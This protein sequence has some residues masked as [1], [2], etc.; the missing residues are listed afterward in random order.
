MLFF[1]FLSGHRFLNKAFATTRQNW[2]VANFSLF[3][4]D[5]VRYSENIT[6]YRLQSY[7]FVSFFSDVI[8]LSNLRLNNLRG[9]CF[10]FGKI[11]ISIVK[12]HQKTKTLFY[13]SEGNTFICVCRKIWTR[14]MLYNFLN[15]QHHSLWKWTDISKEKFDSERL[16]EVL[17]KQN[18]YFSLFSCPLFLRK[19]GKWT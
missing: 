11:L 5:Y 18:I 4:K 6:V 15:S 10:L 13:H 2:R 17:C 9:I 16:Y 14:S 19:R 8:W 1:S 12:Y 3:S 7:C